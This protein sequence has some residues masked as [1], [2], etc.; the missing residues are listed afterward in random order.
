MQQLMASLRQQVARNIVSNYA[1]AIVGGVVFILLTPYVV[2]NLGATGYALWVLVH[3]VGYFI[4]YLDLGLGDAQVKYLADYLGRDDMAGARRLLGT[5][6]SA[7]TIIGAIACAASLC[8]AALPTD[9]LFNV[10]AEQRSLF[11][12]LLTLLAINLLIGFPAALLGRVFIGCQRFDVSNGL[13]IGF[14]V[15]GAVTTVLV[16]QADLGLIGLAWMEILLTAAGGVVDLLLISRLFPGLVIAYTRIDSGIW[17]EL[18][19]YGIWSFLDELITE[20][21]AQLDKLIMPVLLSVSLLTPYS[22]VMALAT[23]VLFV[24]EPITD[25]LFPMAAEL[26]ARGEFAR[27]RQVWR[28]GTRAVIAVAAPTAIITIVFGNAMLAAWVGAD[29]AVLPDGA[30]PLLVINLFFSALLWPATTMLLGIGSVRRVFWFSAIEVAIGL[31]A[32]LLLTPRFGIVGFI[33]A[34]LAANVIAGFALT[35]P[36]IATALTA[37]ISSFFLAGLLKPLLTCLPALAAALT[38]QTFV[39]PAS[40]PELAFALA[41]VMAVHLPAYALFGMTVHERARIIAKLGYAR[42]PGA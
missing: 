25:V 3:A 41:G 10:P 22:L 15:L 9:Q 21:T 33:A 27:L 23:L 38:I 19:S 8:L 24:S 1:A 37:G 14:S 40:I 34:L 29:Y 32:I 36:A 11:A 39:A 12:T 35:L 6:L 17:Q 26:K 7:Y 13:D 42:V 16:L 5:L 2:A 20:G 31:I 28:D 18:K 30:L 4:R